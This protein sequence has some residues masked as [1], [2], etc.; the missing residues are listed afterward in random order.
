[1]FSMLAGAAIGF[2]VDSGLMMNYGSNANYFWIA[3]GMVT[4]ISRKKLL[5]KQRRTPSMPREY[6][7]S[8]SNDNSTEVAPSV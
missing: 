3:L 1:M 5:G 6:S 4:A 2:L 7:S 8:C